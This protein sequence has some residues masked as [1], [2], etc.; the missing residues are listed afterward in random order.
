MTF[1][2]DGW[3]RTLNSWIRNQAVYHRATAFGH[4]ISSSFKLQT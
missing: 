3:I 4:L 2:A 1:Y